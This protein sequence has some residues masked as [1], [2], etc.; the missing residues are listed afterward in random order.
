MAVSVN[1]FEK[2]LASLYEAISF[3]ENTDGPIKF[4]IARDACIQR[5]EF[6]VELAWKNSVKVLGSNATSPKPAIREMAQ[7]NLIDDIQI[8]FSFIEARNKSYHTYNDNIAE[9]VFKT[10]KEFLPHGQTLLGKLKSQ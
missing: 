6:C 7:N 5:F 1:E 10:L 4:K 9:D 8:W 3:T 2:A